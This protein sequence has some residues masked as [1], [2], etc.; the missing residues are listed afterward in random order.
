M[1]SPAPQPSHAQCSSL[2]R[3]S[4]RAPRYLAFAAAAAL[5]TLACSDNTAP[6]PSLLEVAAGD[7]QHAPAGSELPNPV[8]V[9]LR[10]ASQRALVGVHVTW[11]AG[12]GGAGDVI[13]PESETTDGN[14]N[15][16]AR[17][18]L[19]ATAGTHTIVVSANGGAVAYASAFA[20]ALPVG[21][22]HPM[23]LETYEGSG[24]AV[25][26]D[27]VRLPPA[28][29]GDPFRLV[30]TP[31]PGGN[32][33]FEN[34][35]LYTGSTGT[36]W[37][38]PTGITNPVEQPQG[39][40]YLSDPD[41]VYDPDANELR[42]YYRRVTSDNEIWMIRS[43]NGVVWST[44]VLTLHAANHLIVSPTIVRRSSTQWMMWSVNAGAIGCGALSTTVELRRSTDG[45]HW[46]E[47]EATP[48]SNP[49]G[50]PWHIDVEWIH[51]RSEYW[52]VY[53]VKVA[54][55]CT[56]DRLRFATSPDGTH[57][58]TYASPL[59]LH[60][61]T[62][63]LRDIVYRSTVDYDA[64]ADVVTLW[65]SGAKYDRG[66]YSWHT[67]WERMSMTQLFARVTARGAIA[68]RTLPPARLNLPAL[69]NESAP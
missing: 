8:V 49:D 34:P 4:S 13:T 22:V 55:G 35:S 37:T 62:D 9:Q 6:S 57:W 12:T 10:D 27:F 11:S 68:A 66:I 47:P 67:A 15:V 40:G 24:Q 54:G 61:A 26:P 65:Y 5:L 33:G 25:H 52:A 23:P 42:I 45:E 43:S 20:D 51:T 44:P 29:A 16:R 14:G 28:W 7:G 69:T 19:D 56:T 50:Y 32:A 39:I 17:W 41:M 60:G 21:D 1:S 63:Q 36:L 31:Y 46:S 58:T 3:R 30:A 53:P 48:L 59:L 38:V 18:R 2:A 64:A